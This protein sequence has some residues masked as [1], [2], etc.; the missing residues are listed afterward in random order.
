M[1]A[2]GTPAL[3]LTCLSHFVFNDPVRS[4]LPISISGGET[5]SEMLSDLPRVTKSCALTVLLPDSAQPRLRQP[6]GLPAAV[7]RG[8]AVRP[9]PPSP[10]P[11]QTFL[12][13]LVSAVRGLSP[14]PTCRSQIP[15]GLLEPVFLLP[16]PTHHSTWG[17]APQKRE[18]EMPNRLLRA[19]LRGE[20]W[21]QR[22]ESLAQ[23]FTAAGVGVPP[24]A[25]RL[26]GFPTPTPI[27]H[28]CWSPPTSLI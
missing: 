14:S 6:Q 7:G 23:G 4:G 5:G 20:T 26:L 16:V 12:L 9:P 13:R 2:A 21:A 18:K 27:Y 1:T 8:N 10:H 3:C 22:G 17:L 24:R 28:F 15:D 11:A 25:A 19:L